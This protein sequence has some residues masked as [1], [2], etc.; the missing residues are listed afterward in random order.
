MLII[1]GCILVLVLGALY[2]TYRFY[3]GKNTNYALTEATPLLEQV[4]NQGMSLNILQK[5]SPFDYDYETC[6]R[7][8]EEFQGED[9]NLAAL[10]AE[11]A[12]D[13]LTEQQIQNLLA[14]LKYS[15]LL[16]A[17]KEEEKLV[18]LVRSMK[19]IRCEKGD[20]I[21][22]QGDT[23]GRSYY[24]MESG[25][26]DVFVF[27]QFRVTIQPGW[28]FGELSFVFGAPRS[29]S[30]IASE[31]STLWVLDR[32]HF[33]RIMMGTSPLDCMQ[34][35]RQ[36]S[37]QQSDDE[38]SEDEEEHQVTEMAVKQHYGTDFFEEDRV[39]LLSRGFLEQLL[40]QD[41]IGI[42]HQIEMALQE[43]QE[44]SLDLQSNTVTHC[45]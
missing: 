41:Y 27:D 34:I 21:I 30:C 26:I 40:E 29:A 6:N 2:I 19:K 18:E 28:C 4:N 1:L 43:L 38:P 39:C 23:S 3:G 33:D 22:Q 9:S 42:P 32:S 45:G 44:M 31:T 12:D 8:L 35:T 20:V 5:N 13:V 7:N 25:A 15:R 11:D 16:S 10:Q 37:L 36:E 14:S 17:I 24:V